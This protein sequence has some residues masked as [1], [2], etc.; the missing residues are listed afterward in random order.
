[1]DEN[2]ENQGQRTDGCGY[3]LH[4]CVSGWLKHV[5]YHNH[6]YTEYLEKQKNKRYSVCMQTDAV[7]Y[8]VVK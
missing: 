8:S 1:M 6:K 2:E 7:Y 3:G 4:N 5:T